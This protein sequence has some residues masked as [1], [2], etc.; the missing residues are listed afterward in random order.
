MLISEYHRFGWR[1][2]EVGALANALANA[3]VTAAHSQQPYTEEMLFGIGGGIGFAYFLF[4]Q[5]GAHRI[6]VGTRIHTKETERPE[7]VQTILQRL[8]APAHVQNSSSASAAS[9]NLRRNLEQGQAPLIW[10]DPQKLSYL[11]MNTALNCYYSVIVFGVD[12]GAGTASLADRCPGPVTLPLEDLRAARET[13][14]SPKYRAMLVQKSADGGDIRSAVESGIRDCIVQMNQG[15]GITNFGLRGMEKWATVLT[16]TKEKKSWA[17]IFPPGANLFD[18][19]YSIFCQIS[20]RDSGGC[21]DRLL[22]ADFLVEAA[23]VLNRP[24]LRDVADQYRGLE[25]M[26][27]S[28][29]ENHLPG[30]I[31]AFAEARELTLR[32]TRAFEEKGAEAAEEVQ[33]IRARLDQIAAEC[34]EQF[35]L[36]FNDARNLLHEL[37]QQI[38]NLHAAETDIVRALEAAVGIAETHR[39][40]TP[41]ADVPSTPTPA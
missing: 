19:L 37:K 13:S 17:K 22:Y 30:D 34:R 33:S 38:L 7:F 14:W 5:G 9:G 26:W 6:H 32:R 20:A 24:A 8:S 40:E 39:T 11:G 1:D 25:Q 36:S 10:V 28:V 27:R 15:L 3:G 29:A 35:P 16:S 18:S 21:A 2:C 23:D 4:E 12:E 31:P 41:Q